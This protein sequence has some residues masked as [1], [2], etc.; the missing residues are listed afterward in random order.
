VAR[1]DSLRHRLVDLES[2]LGVVE[3]GMARY[4]SLAAAW[5]SCSCMPGFAGI[6]EGMPKYPISA[7]ETKRSWEIMPNGHLT[8]PN[9]IKSRF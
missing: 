9:G 7:P 3:L 6:W 2:G 4:S 1:L 8:G 5:T